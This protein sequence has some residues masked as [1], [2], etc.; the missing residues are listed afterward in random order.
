M[1]E[2]FNP[3][4]GHAPQLGTA[5]FSVITNPFPFFQL[6]IK[7]LRLFTGE[8]KFELGETQLEENIGQQNFSRSLE[9]Y[10]LSTRNT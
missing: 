3:Q 1:N 6:S 8:W 7:H 4:R 5:V 9:L 2:S 10:F